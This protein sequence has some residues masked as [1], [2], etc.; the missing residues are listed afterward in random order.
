MTDILLLLSP[1]WKKLRNRL[2]ASRHDRLR[3]FFV[4]GLVAILWA[5]IYVV[6][7][8]A[9]TYFTAEEM[10]GTIAATKLL[11]MILVTFTF[12]V[13]ISNIITTFSTFFLSEDLELLM[14][15]PVPS[16]S[17]PRDS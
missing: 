2:R 1:R 8:K 15:A 13:I 12:V 14:A 5:V 7:V 11:S 17:T 9:L 6:F 4:L 3:Y 10:F 16:F